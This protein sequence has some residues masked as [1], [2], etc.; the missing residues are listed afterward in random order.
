MNDDKEII[1]TD[2]KGNKVF[3][4]DEYCFIEVIQDIKL[5]KVTC[6]FHKRIATKTPPATILNYKN[7]SDAVVGVK[8]FFN[9]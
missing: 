5:R 4:G 9:R 3:Q 8:H 6:L 7:R 2:V 1:F